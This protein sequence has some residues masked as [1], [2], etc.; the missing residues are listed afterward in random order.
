MAHQRVLVV[1]YGGKSRVAATAIAY[2]SS[3]TASA[4][5][6]Y[7]PYRYRPNDATSTPISSTWA[8]TSPSR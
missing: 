3:D 6:M 5:H 4:D 2:T 7:C 8:D 1:L